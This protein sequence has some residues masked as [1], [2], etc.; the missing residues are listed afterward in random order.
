MAT[1]E[2]FD[3]TKAKSIYDFT[4]KDT[5]GENISLEK[6]RGNVVI[7]VNIASQ[8]GLTKSN[9][10]ELTK[11]KEKYYD[12]GKIFVFLITLKKW[13]DF[14]IFLI[15]LRKIPWK[16]AIFLIF[17]FMSKLSLNGILFWFERFQD[18][19][20]W[21]SHAINLADKCQKAMEKRWFAIYKRKMLILV[22][23]LQK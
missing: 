16:F 3:Y 17:N 2:D 19:A 5:F 1:G 11:L 6:Y 18:Y 15:I 10:E 14:H 22:I 23:F 8:C 20:Y 7:I 13:H 21:A 9:Y 12:R 4:V